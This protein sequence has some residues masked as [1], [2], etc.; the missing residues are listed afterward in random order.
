MDTVSNNPSNS[1][2][3]PGIQVDTVSN[4]SNPAGGTWHTGGHSQQQS[5]QLCWRYLT[6]TW[7]RSQQHLKP[8]TQ[9]G[10]TP[11]TLPVVPATQMNIQSATK[12]KTLPWVPAIQ[13]DKV[14]LGIVRVRQQQ[15]FQVCYG[16]P[17]HP[18][19][20]AT[21]PTSF[22]GRYPPDRWICCAY[23]CRL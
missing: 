11:P 17:P 15:S 2:R 9:S 1:A 7:I 19:Q 6:H 23:S 12:P 4:P 8:T 10:A 20:S 21:R 22:P 14:Q 13:V 5:L 18:T 3:V 16:H